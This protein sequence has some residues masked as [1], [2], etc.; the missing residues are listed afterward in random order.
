MPHLRKK[1]DR[2]YAE[3]YDPDRHP[4]RKWVPLRTGDK[5]AATNKM[6]N[7]DRDHARKEYDP[8]EDRS[9]E[10]GVT[11][12][13][14]TEDYHRSKTELRPDSEANDRSVLARLVA[15][16]P[17][18]H[19]VAHTEPRHVKAFVNAPKPDGTPR[20][21][22]TRDSYLSRVRMFFVWCIERGI[23]KGKNPAD[24]VP[25]PKVGQKDPL[26]LS[27]DEVEAFLKAVQDDA[28]ANASRLKPGEVTWVADAAIVTV[29]TGLRASELCHLRWDAV[30]LN[31]R[32]LKVKA[33]AGFKTKSGHER[34]VP[35]AGDALA[36][37]QELYSVRTDGSSG[38]VFGGTASRSGT[39][40]HINREYLN[41]RF[42]H[43]AKLAGL[44]ARHSFHSLR[45]TYA[46]WLVQGGT[47]IYRVQKLLGHAD[48][49]TTMK[50]AFLAPD[51]FTADV[52][53][54]FGKGQSARE[55]RPLPWLRTRRARA[56]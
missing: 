45:R 39:T 27:R 13:Q 47:D 40:A 23:L 31:G 32:R 1:G 44:D 49:K 36:K 17:P 46:S 2:Y 48:I 38:Y 21:D 3:F 6:V 7:L 43:Y 37:L 15:S 22:A 28:A 19:L 41:S 5:Q 34:T 51:T 42:K 29:G 24:A 25:R 33:S 50:Y 18:G 12:D 26:F 10:E 11:V 52:E 54:V 55:T 56:V 16:L 53:R 20:S 14:A 30:D 35:L 4:N 9:P 8:W